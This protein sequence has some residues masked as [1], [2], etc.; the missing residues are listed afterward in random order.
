MR[1]TDDRL[2][3]PAPL[4]V[5][6]SSSEKLDQ[7]YSKTCVKRPLSKR[8]KIVFKTN[9]RFMQVKSIAECPKVTFCNTFD[10]H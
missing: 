8:P 10:L 3:S 7:I 5:S 1:F 2:S 4:G 6:F 9:Y